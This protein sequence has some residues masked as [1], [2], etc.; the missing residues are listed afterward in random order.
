VVEREGGSRT[1]THPVQGPLAYEQVAFNLANR[2]EFK[3][4][5][6]VPSAG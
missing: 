2:P 4:V 3:L 5:I 1:F 6:L